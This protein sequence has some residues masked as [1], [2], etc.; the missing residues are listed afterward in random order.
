MNEW[1]LR[2]AMRQL[3]PRTEHF[4]GIEDCGDVEFV[5]RFH[6]ESAPLLWLGVS[7]GAWLYA[8]TP[9]F[10]VL[11]PLP[12]FWLPRGLADKHANKIAS[13]PI[14][15]LR[16]PIFLVKMIA[17]L[18]WGADPK[19]REAIGLPPYGPDPDAYRQSDDVVRAR[20]LPLAETAR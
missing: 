9:L 15:L 19:V 10:T 7:A 17:G 20:R 18:C 4:P 5:A 16:Q 6:R 2:S 12:S 8:L 14:Y 1:L 3:Y 11:V 13:L